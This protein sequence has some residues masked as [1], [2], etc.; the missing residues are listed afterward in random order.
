[1]NIVAMRQERRL[2]QIAEIKGTIKKII[3]SGKE[4]KEIS[5]SKLR[6]LVMSNLGVTG[7]TANEFICVA[8]F[9][10]GLEKKD[11]AK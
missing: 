11:V 2:K 8:L 7:R 3:D 9:E 10:L 6:M 1:M 5:F 4:P